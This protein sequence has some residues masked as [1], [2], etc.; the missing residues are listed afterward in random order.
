MA[1]T[2][3]DYLI[4]LGQFIKSKRTEVRLRHALMA[5]A[6]IARSIGGWRIEFEKQAR[7]TAPQ[8]LDLASEA[9]R[10]SAGS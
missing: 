9:R 2:S 10:L 8:V 6:E 4:A 7:E 5:D 1:S 3:D